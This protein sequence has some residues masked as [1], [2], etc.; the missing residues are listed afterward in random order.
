M[1][2]SSGVRAVCGA[3]AAMGMALGI[4]GAAADDV[5]GSESIR[6]LVPTV[7]FRGVL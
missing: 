5:V 4:S 1:A 3:L 7:G 2:K 6:Y